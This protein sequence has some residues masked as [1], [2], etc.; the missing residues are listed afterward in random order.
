MKEYPENSSWIS[1]FSG[2][3]YCEQRFYCNA[4]VCSADVSLSGTFTAM[5]FRSRPRTRVPINQD[6]IQKFSMGKMQLRFCKVPPFGNPPTASSQYSLYVPICS[7]SSC[8][9]AVTWMRVVLGLISYGYLAAP[10]TLKLRKIPPRTYPQQTDLGE[11][12]WYLMKHDFTVIS[13]PVHYCAF[14]IWE[15]LFFARAPLAVTL[16]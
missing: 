13:R 14:S 4:M 8:I 10:A 16:Q 15:F 12:V 6:N 1:G 5:V 7:S 2:F 11:F 3:L 9:D